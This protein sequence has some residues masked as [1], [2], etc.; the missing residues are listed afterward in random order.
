MELCY[1]KVNFES[2]VD[3]HLDTDYLRCNPNFH[4]HE[5]W[6]FVLVQMEGNNIMFMQLLIIFRCIIP[7]TTQWT[8]HSPATHASES[9]PVD[10]DAQVLT[11]VHPFNAK[12]LQHEQPKKDWDLEFIRVWACKWTES[13]FIFAESIIRGALM[14]KDYLKDHTNVDDWLVIDVIDSDMFLHL[15]EH[16]NSVLRLNKIYISC[17]ILSKSVLPKVHWIQC[18]FILWCTHAMRSEV[19]FPWKKQKE[20]KMVEECSFGWVS[21]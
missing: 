20:D 1:P 19:D 18:L 8:R 6:D 4:G 17:M 15:Q 3:W 13:H 11:L 5:C 10:L 9:Q 21:G 14:V 12:I 7:N 16:R 2:Q